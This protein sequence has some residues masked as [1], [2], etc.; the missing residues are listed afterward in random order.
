MFQNEVFC[1]LTIVE[2]FC[3]VM[4]KI[5]VVSLTLQLLGN[6]KIGR[7]YQWNMINVLF[8]HY[9]CN[10]WCIQ[11]FGVTCIWAQILYYVWNGRIIVPKCVMSLM[12]LFLAITKKINEDIIKFVLEF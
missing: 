2:F 5:Y 3:G 4:H 9:P 11:K 10:V 12:D 7:H 8:V 6:P 1:A